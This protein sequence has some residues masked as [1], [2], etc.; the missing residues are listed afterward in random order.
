MNQI[1]IING[2]TLQVMETID[3]EHNRENIKKLV[4]SYIPTRG[5]VLLED[6]SSDCI[7]IAK[8]ADG[9]TIGFSI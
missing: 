7:T 5:A 2:A 3:E 9:T 8:Y 6:W 4:D 1:R